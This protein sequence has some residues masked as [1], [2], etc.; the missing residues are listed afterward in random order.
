[1]R[2]RSGFSGL[3]RL[4]AGGALVL[5]LLVPLAE[6]LLRPLLGKGIANADSLVEAAEYALKL[7]EGRRK[8]GL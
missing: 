5:M 6:M 3:E 8:K 4:L 2:V 7:L 1:M